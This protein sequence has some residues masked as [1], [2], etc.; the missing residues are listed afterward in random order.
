MLRD[1]RADENRLFGIAPASLFIVHDDVI[2]VHTLHAIDREG[3]FFP[4][5]HFIFS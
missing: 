5:F 2:M 3:V 1:I 4:F